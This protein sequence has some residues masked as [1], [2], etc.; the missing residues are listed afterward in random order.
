MSLPG[1]VLEVSKEQGSW[2]SHSPF[3]CLTTLKENFFSLYSAEVSLIATVPP[4]PFTFKW[5]KTPASCLLSLPCF[6][7]SKAS[8]TG[9]LSSQALQP[10]NIFPLSS[11]SCPAGKA[12]NWAR[13]SGRNLNSA[14]Q[15][16][17][18][19]NMF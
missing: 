4:C 14:K 12:K 16:G 6:R 15:M 19:T 10:L 18:D 3:Q 8:A 9:L 11:L 17:N 7:L 5:L 13:S 2:T 1:K